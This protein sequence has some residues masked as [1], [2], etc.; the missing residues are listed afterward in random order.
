MG[1]VYPLFLSIAARGA[2]ALLLFLSGLSAAR[3]AA[4]AG[5]FASIDPT[6][7]QLMQANPGQPLPVIVEMEHVSSPLGGANVQLAQQALGL[8]RGV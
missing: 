7:Q 6:L 2:L 5:L 4:A 1:R 3:P 8:L